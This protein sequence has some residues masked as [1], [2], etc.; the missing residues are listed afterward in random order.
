MTSAGT[1]NRRIGLIALAILMF[2]LAIAPSTAS[3]ASTR[4]EYVAQVDPI[5]QQENISQKAVVRSLNKRVKLL[6]KRGFDRQKPSKPI[7]RLIIRGYDR[8]AG[9]QRGANG[10]IALV[11]PA[12]GDQTTT[13]SW[14]QQRAAFATV[15]QR[16]GHLF[17]QQKQ[18]KALALFF[19]ALRIEDQ[20]EHLIEPF[21]FRFCNRIFPSF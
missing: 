21:G 12:P 5:C 8:L 4:A 16:A 7:A 6:A 2:A 18:R 15:F 19:R 17:A 13:S 11:T 20:A 3:A 9:I 1:L 10:S 14:I